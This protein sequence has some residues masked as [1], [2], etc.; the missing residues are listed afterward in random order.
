MIS[1]FLSMAADCAAIAASLE[2]PLDVRVEPTGYGEL[3]TDA[4]TIDR[5]GYPPS[6]P[7]G[8]FVYRGYGTHVRSRDR[9]FA[10]LRPIDA[11]KLAAP[12]DYRIHRNAN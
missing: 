5:P 9:R 2:R 1:A 12:C 7:V 8:P 3:S 4:Q 6:V 11:F 10:L